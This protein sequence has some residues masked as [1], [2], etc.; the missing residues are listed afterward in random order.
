MGTWAS[1]PGAIRDL[2]LDEDPTTA[3]AFG[4]AGPSAPRPASAGGRRP[5]LESGSLSLGRPRGR[6]L[7]PGPDSPYRSDTWTAPKG[8][9]VRV[10]TSS[11]TY[12]PTHPAVAPCRPPPCPTPR[13][14]SK[15]C[16]EVQIFMVPAAR[17]MSGR[18]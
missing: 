9:V 5:G 3:G 8:R 11:P 4:R 14:Y 15:T 10:A 18:R 12:A 6:D 7:E 2:V 16:S 17:A 1:T 13:T